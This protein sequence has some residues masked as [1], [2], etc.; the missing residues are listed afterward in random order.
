MLAELLI[1]VHTPNQP[2]RSENYSV[3]T[4]S[5]LEAPRDAT[6]VTVA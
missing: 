3:S 5:P 2:S 4:T 1:Q 6:L